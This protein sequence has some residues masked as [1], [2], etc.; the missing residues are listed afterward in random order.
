MGSFAASLWAVLLSWVRGVAAWLWAALSS[1][2]AGTLF[3][4]LRDNWK[5]LAL[6]LC[7]AGTVI[8]L[9]VYFLRW[10][11]HVVFRSW[12]E[13]RR[14]RREGMLAPDAAPPETVFQAETREEDTPADFPDPD[15]APAFSGDYA[16]AEPAEERLPSRRRRVDT[17]RPGLLSRVSSAIS[18]LSEEEPSVAHLSYRAPAKSLSESF[19]APYVPE[20]WRPSDNGQTNLRR[21][22]RVRSAPQRDDR[23]EA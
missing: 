13:R 9:T 23:G 11:P 17:R 19:H 5:P 4:W 21:G 22:R 3:Q 12:L 6:L 14:L 10:Q 20:S 8:D 7:A 18:L 16:P 1:P 2:V 15:P